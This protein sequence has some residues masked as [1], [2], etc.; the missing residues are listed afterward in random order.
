MKDYDT[1]NPNS[2]GTCEIDFTGKLNW[3][4]A[5]GQDVF[6]FNWVIRY[7]D[8]PAYV[9]TSNAIARFKHVSSDG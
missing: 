9:D 3:F 2:Y 6:T 8:I 4:Y 1:T 5:N 7:N